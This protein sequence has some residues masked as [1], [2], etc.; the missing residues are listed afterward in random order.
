MFESVTCYGV[1]S[2]SVVCTGQSINPP[3]VTARMGPC[4]TIGGVL[5][6]SMH[7]ALVTRPHQP[8]CDGACVRVSE[9]CVLRCH[10]PVRRLPRH[11]CHH[12][13][14]GPTDRPHAPRATNLRRHPP[15]A[16]RIARPACRAWRRPH[17]AQRLAPPAAAPSWPAVR[18]C[19][20]RRV[21]APARTRQQK[22]SSSSKPCCASKTPPPRSTST[23]A[24]WA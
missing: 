15:Q 12:H 24:C 9:A 11:P 2:F 13:P 21:C 16:A 10:A 22:T 5:H 4:L 19:R 6:T 23:R 3:R 20:P 8:A 18:S 1:T 7:A 17:T 14:P